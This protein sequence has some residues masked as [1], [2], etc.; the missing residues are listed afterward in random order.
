MPHPTPHA[1]DAVDDLNLQCCDC[2]TMFVF[3][4]SEQ[5]FFRELGFQTPR[6][7]RPCRE[8]RKAERAQQE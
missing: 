6:R 5:E 8:R 7:C 3:T 4:I 2:G 1:T